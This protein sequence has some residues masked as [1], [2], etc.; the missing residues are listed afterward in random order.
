[1][2]EEGP[3]AAAP[4]MRRIPDG[5]EYSL[6]LADLAEL[7]Q[8]ADS[9]PG[10]LV[11]RAAG[12]ALPAAVAGLAFQSGVW[13]EIEL[14]AALLDTLDARGATPPY[15]AIYRVV[16]LAGTGR[17]DSARA[18]VDQI[19]NRT[20]RPQFEAFLAGAPFLPVADTAA[21]SRARMAMAEQATTDP[22]YR[23]GLTYLGALADL[24]L[25][26]NSAALALA[27]TLDAAADTLE[28]ADSASV[29]LWARSIRATAA[30]SRDD[31]QAALE[32]LGEVDGPITFEHSNGWMLDRSRERYLLATLLIATGRPD[33]AVPWLEHGIRGGG[34]APLY[35]PMAH[36]RLGEAHEMG[37]REPEAT[38]AYGRFLRYFAH[39]EPS[40]RPYVRQARDALGRLTGERGG[41]D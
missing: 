19:A 13:G 1:M 24:R 14:S 18:S 26:R 27:D 7:Y 34:G 20:L 39:A 3:Q 25:G 22:R 10:A 6:A 28:V 23:L 17:P 21:L 30:L 8:P 11:L 41:V 32:L 15:M 4:W 37:G 5:G 40:M 36:L 2:S 16:M 38:L 9:A 12:D 33:E 29:E 31:A 35:L